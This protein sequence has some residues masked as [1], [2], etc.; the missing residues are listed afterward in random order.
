MSHLAIVG[1]KLTAN[2][3]RCK[4]LAKYRAPM[5]SL[6][7]GEERGGQVR[8]GQRWTWKN[9]NKVEEEDREDKWREKRQRQESDWPAEGK[10]DK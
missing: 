10:G 8:R 3:F 7:R 4:W 5:N 1:L 2:Q 6:K 9:K